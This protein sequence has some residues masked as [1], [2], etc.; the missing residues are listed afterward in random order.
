MSRSFTDAGMCVTQGFAVLFI[1]GIGVEFVGRE[2]I[3]AAVEWLQRAV[4][5][6]ASWRP[7]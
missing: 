6:G 7:R 4:N 2:Q 3:G 5:V 1:K